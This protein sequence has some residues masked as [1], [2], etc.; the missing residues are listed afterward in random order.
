MN[1]HLKTKFI[2][3]ILN[4]H[5]DNSMIIAKVAPTGL[6]VKTSSDVLHRL[7]WYGHAP[8]GFPRASTATKYSGETLMVSQICLHQ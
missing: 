6:S 1:E 3:F 5:P 7:G 4:Q 8:Q 2:F